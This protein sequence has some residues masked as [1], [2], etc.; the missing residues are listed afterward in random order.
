MRC[1]GDRNVS[2]IS[3]VN[4]DGCTETISENSETR[5]PPAAV[6]LCS[7]GT[8]TIRFDTY[9]LDNGMWRE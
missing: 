5:G 3:I 6:E 7:V 1:L 4:P 8:I 9:D 2:A